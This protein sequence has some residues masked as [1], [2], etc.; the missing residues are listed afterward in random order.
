M[1]SIFI[2]SPVALFLLWRA[3]RELPAAEAGKLSRAIAA[4]ES[5]VSST[6]M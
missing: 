6:P 3:S 2:V 4:G 5:L 1:L